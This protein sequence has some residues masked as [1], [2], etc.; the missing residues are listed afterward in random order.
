MTFK[1]IIGSVSDKN[2]PFLNRELIQFPQ[3]EQGR[4]TTTMLSNAPYVE[5]G[6]GVMNIFKV[7]RVD[8]V[9]RLTYLDRPNVPELFGNKGL[10]VRAAVAVD[11]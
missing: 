9:Q 4:F 2:N 7:L 10:A 6:F 3:N 8:L 1:A 11:F 5:A